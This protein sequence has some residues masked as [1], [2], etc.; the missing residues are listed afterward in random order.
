L[1]IDALGAKS[2][3]AMPILP[4]HACDVYANCVDVGYVTQLLMQYCCCLAKKLTELVPAN[5]QRLV[6]GPEA[7]VESLMMK[8]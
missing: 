6:L 5:C 8:A 1:R 2:I 3:Q 4:G 7:V